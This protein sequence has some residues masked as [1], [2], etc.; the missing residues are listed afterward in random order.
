MVC[1]RPI[2]P[3]FTRFSKPRSIRDRIHKSMS[4]LNVYRDT[5]DLPW[6]HLFCDVGMLYTCINPGDSPFAIASFTDRSA[7]SRSAELDH[8]IDLGFRRNAFNSDLRCVLLHQSYGERFLL[9]REWPNNTS[10]QQFAQID[11]YDHCR[12]VDL[13]RLFRISCI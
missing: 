1:N 6:Y 12:L 2:D 13:S 4:K 8:I 5:I 7:R 10:T 11:L 9:S 3:L